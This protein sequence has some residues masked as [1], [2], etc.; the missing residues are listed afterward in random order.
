MNIE[1]DRC[2]MVRLHVRLIS[3]VATALCLAF[4]PVMLQRAAAQPTARCDQERLLQLET[5]QQYIKQAIKDTQDMTKY[6]LTTFAALMVVIQVAATLVQ[7]RKEERAFRQ[8]AAREDALDEK[9]RTREADLEIQRTDREQQL[10]NFWTQ[11]ESS[12]EKRRTER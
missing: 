10:L 7:A 2:A 4:L 11:R 6:L 3:A 8:Q 1:T 9:R 5:E 12:V